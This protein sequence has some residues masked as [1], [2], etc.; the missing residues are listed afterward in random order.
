M[1]ERTFTVEFGGYRRETY[2]K[3]IPS[4]SGVYC[5]YEG[6]LNVKKDE[7]DTVSLHKLIYIGEA[8]D[9]NDRINKPHEKWDD[10]KKHVR[11]GKLLWFSYAEIQD[12]KDRK[13]VE[14]ALIFQHKPP[15]NEEC[16]NLFTYDKTTI[17]TENMNEFLEPEF[18]VE[19]TE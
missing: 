6:T 12:E 14:C 17:I 1:V 19:K 18:T 3:N 10:W 7:P 5:V 15:E 8:G 2:V 4:I 13:R 9:I 16:K 11:E